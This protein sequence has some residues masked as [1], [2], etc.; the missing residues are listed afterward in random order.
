MVTAKVQNVN[1]TLAQT[2]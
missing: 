1:Q 2:N